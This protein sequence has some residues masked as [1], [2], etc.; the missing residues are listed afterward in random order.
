MNKVIN[1][2]NNKPFNKV[3]LEAYYDDNAINPET[4]KPYSQAELQTAYEKGK[5]LKIILDYIPNIG[6]IYGSHF[7]SKIL[8]NE[9]GLTKEVYA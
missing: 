9:N 4:N 1:P 8:I 6:Y 7:V 5:E 3:E 2:K